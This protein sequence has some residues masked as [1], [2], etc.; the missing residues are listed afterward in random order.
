M[1]AWLPSIDDKLLAATNSARTAAVAVQRLCAVA[2]PHA[3]PVRWGREWNAGRFPQPGTCPNKVPNAQAAAILSIFVEISIR[4]TLDELWRRIVDY[5]GTRQ[6]L[7]VDLELSV[8]DNGGL[9][10]RSG[11]PRFNERPLAFRFPLFFPAWLM[12]ASG[13]MMRADVAASK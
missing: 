7:A 11:E 9:R 12:Y 8:A 5:L 3:K 4:G 13:L 2:A 6:H 1:A 10:L